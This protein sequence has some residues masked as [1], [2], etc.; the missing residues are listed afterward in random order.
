MKTNKKKIDELLEGDLSQNL[1][2]YRLWILNR[3]ISLFQ[4]KD[5]P[6]EI[7][8]TDMSAILLL[9]GTVGFFK[10]TDTN[11]FIAVRGSFSGHINYYGLGEDYTYA[12]TGIS[13]NR[14]VYNP[15]V[16]QDTDNGDIVVCKNT[17]L[18]L[19]MFYMVKKYAD[20]LANADTSIRVGIMNT[21]LTNIISARDDTEK[22]QIE[23]ALKKMYLGQPS[24]VVRKTEQPFAGIGDNLPET[25]QTITVRET[26]GSPEL[27][28]ILQARDSVLAMLGNEIGFAFKDKNKR[29]QVNSEELEGLDEWCKT[30]V[31]DMLLQRKEFCKM[32]NELYGLNTS[33]ELSDYT[34]S[35]NET[36]ERSGDDEADSNETDMLQSLQS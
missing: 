17:S 18:M 6:S 34:D 31:Y 29:A 24:V 11:R 21:R 1:I 27:P 14:K 22:T 9:E 16:S 36:Q 12:M 5:F 7:D 33:V 25:W 20:L 4:F 23:T 19:S 30:I 13:G 3:L 15:Y 10:E 32:I 26:T 8:L 35:D 2:Y 28:T